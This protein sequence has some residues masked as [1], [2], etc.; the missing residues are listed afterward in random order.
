MITEIAKKKLL[1][2]DYCRKKLKPE[3]M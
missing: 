3:T 1:I 2:I